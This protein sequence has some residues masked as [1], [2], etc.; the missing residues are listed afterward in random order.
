M[1]KAEFKI[2]E[3]KVGENNPP[4]IIAEVGSNFNQSMEVAKEMI[5]VAKESG[6]DA[7]KFQLFRA[8]Y[9]YPDGGELYDIF[10]SIELNAEWIPELTGYAEQC[11]ITFLVSAFDYE[12][13][14]VLEKNNIPAHKI[15]S[16]E[17]TNLAFL[18]HVASTDKP[19]IISTG[20]CDMV[21]VE[22]AINI[23]LGVG[24]MQIALLQCGSMYPLP[25]NMVNLS[26]IKKFHDNFA[27]PVG[28]SD[29][30][31]DNT[32]AIC[33][34]GMGATIFEKH[35]TLDRNAKG[36]DHFYALESNELKEYVSSIREAHSALGDGIKQMLPEEKKFGRREGLYAAKDL[37]AGEVI[38]VSDLI[39]RRPAI[40]LRERYKSVVIGATVVNN[41]NKDEPIKWSDIQF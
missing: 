35:F 14:G 17:T 7:V 31:L 34:V 20:M 6:S 13:V 26:V 24:N 23:C 5:D 37:F 21:D 39:L 38:E 30:T 9:L 25:S 4:Y 3:K 2:A 36:P 28:F 33:A 12:S 32:S 22:E 8:D 16:S 18:N 10:K 19:V 1:L 29:H 41:I 27:C 40:E 15:A 11:G